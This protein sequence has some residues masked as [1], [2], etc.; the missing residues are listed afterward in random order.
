[1]PSP[2]ERLL[3]AG[4]IALLLGAPRPAQAQAASCPAPGE[5]AVVLTAAPTGHRAAAAADTPRVRLNDV[6]VLRV[7]N[8][9]TLVAQRG[10]AEA[11]GRPR[12]LV[13][14]ID[15]RPLPG[16]QVSLAGDPSRDSL[17]ADLRRNEASREAW[18]R[19]L[20]RPFRARRDLMVS[21][22]IAD[23]F[24]VQT[25]ARIRFD[26]SAS[27]L[28]VVAVA[29]FL[30]MVIGVLA[31]GGWTGRMLRDEPVE[32]QGPGPRP[33]S[34]S[35]VQLA[36]WFV[37]VLTAYLLIGLTT[38][39]YEN[40]I[41]GST[42]ILL[43][44]AVGTRAGAAAADARRNDPAP[45]ASRNAE[46]ARLQNEIAADQQR[47]ELL[48][49]AAEDRSAPDAQRRASVTDLAT[50][51]QDHARHQL[52]ARKAYNVSV[53]FFQDTL[54]DMNGI[55]LHR[56]QMAVWTIVLSVVFLVKSYQTMSMPQFNDTLLLLM[57]ISSGAYVG[58]KT[59]EPEAP[60]QP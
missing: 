1:M 20:G 13:L 34:L 27:P 43:G 36:W 38:G 54:G 42:L 50:T 19:V 49:G 28:A 59:S 7:R 21:V 30:L 58:L 52:A 56:Y 41:T 48:E 12:P 57:G 29:G 11:A 4:G 46:L 44:I 22:A 32:P 26:Y 16:V 45:V 17:L 24:P 47:A 55:S 31:W 23:S 35:R 53:S 9:A 3:V 51:V 2:T 37:V 5:P 15:G 8:L 10:C 14:Y 6:M 40:I 18:N 25:A 33:W 60:R 39:D